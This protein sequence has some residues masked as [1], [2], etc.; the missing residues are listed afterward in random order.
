MM[1]F[2]LNPNETRRSQAKRS[3]SSKVVCTKM[4]ET[5]V[6]LVVIHGCTKVLKPY[7]YFLRTWKLVIRRIIN[8][9]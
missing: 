4:C 5:D 8:H 9:A 7:R 2:L 6:R 1:W 3:Q